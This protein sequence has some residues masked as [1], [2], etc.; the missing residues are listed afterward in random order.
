MFCMIR[1]SILNVAV[2]GLNIGL[3]HV[4]E[5]K[6]NQKVRLIAICDYDKPWLDYCKGG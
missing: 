4:E 3:G 6:K 2:M 5:Y 1:D